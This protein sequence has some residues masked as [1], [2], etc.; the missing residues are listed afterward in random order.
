MDITE[1]VV[2]LAKVMYLD[3]ALFHHG[4][5]TEINAAKTD[6]H[7]LGQDSLAG[8][9]TL[10]QTVQDF[11]LDFLLETSELLRGGHEAQSSLGT[12]P[13]CCFTIS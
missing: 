12:L 7:L 5:E 8:I 4:L 1:L 13:P 2:T 9:G 10:L 11:K 6:T 3:P